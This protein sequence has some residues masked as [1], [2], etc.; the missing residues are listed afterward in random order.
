MDVTFID[1]RKLKKLK[2]LSPCLRLRDAELGK[3]STVHLY[4]NFSFMPWFLAFRFPEAAT[5]TNTRCWLY[6]W[7][8]S[9]EATAWASLIDCAINRFPNRIFANILRYRIRHSG[10]FDIWFRPNWQGNFSM[11]DHWNV[12]WGRQTATR[13]SAR[14]MKEGLQQHVSPC[15]ERH[16]FRQGPRYFAS[17]NTLPQKFLKSPTQIGID[18]ENS[19]IVASLLPIPT[20]THPFTNDV[21]Y[22]KSCTYGRGSRVKRKK[23]MS[24]RS[25]GGA[26]ADA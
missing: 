17:R 4:G 18:K 14:W 1:E 2:E 10:A 3:P 16:R 20:F 7:A 13:T 11:P 23:R 12:S 21:L 26:G 15:I 22:L 19:D 5:K 8:L 6:C 25:W 24:R 9:R